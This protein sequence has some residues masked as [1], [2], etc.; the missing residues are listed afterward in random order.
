MLT[1]SIYNRSRIDNFDY[2]DFTQ[3]DIKSA[4]SSDRTTDTG[5]LECVSR[6]G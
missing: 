1:R 3:S 2:H 4:R 6:T 5:L